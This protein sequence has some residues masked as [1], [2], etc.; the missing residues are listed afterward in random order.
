MDRAVWRLDPPPDTVT[1]MSPMLV[2]L[3]PSLRKTGLTPA[4]IATSC[5]AKRRADAALMTTSPGESI[6]GITSVPRDAKP[7]SSKKRAMP[8]AANRWH[9]P[10]GRRKLRLKTVPVPG[11]H[12]RCGTGRIGNRAPGSGQCVHAVNECSDGGELVVDGCVGGVCV[13]LCLRGGL[14]LSG[15]LALDRVNLLIDPPQF[16]LTFA[17][18]CRV[19]LLLLQQCPPFLQGVHH[20]LEFRGHLGLVDL[21]QK[22]RVPVDGL[23]I[24]L[25][26]EDRLVADLGAPHQL[27]ELDG[28]G[29]HLRA[30]DKGF[31]CFFLTQP[32]QFPRR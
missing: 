28:E 32:A 5:D 15:L 3:P 9:P 31:C 12:A 24:S 30:F 18:R 13:A 11:H 26:L 25:Q 2:T 19:F 17:C 6:A 4:F 22:G 1:L 23:Q 27:V 21:A 16:L 8:P 29:S 7:P 20:R 14:P 10:A